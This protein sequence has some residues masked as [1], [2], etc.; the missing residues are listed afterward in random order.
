MRHTILKV[1]A[2]FDVFSYPLT[3]DEL[4]QYLGVHST[5]NEL[6]FEALQQLIETRIIRQHQAFLYLGS[7]PSVV[8]R[9]ISGNIRA[10]QR[11]RQARFY[12]RII[13]GFPFV[14]G[15]FLSGSIS[16][17]FM[18]DNDDIDYFIVTTPDRL[19]IARSMLTIFKKV[20]LLNSHKNFCI[21]YFVDQNHL[22]IQE[23]NRF[24]AT[25]LAFIVPMYDQGV[26]N[27]IINQNQWVRQFYPF[28]KE[29][30]AT[31]PSL[32]PSLFKRLL[33]YI[34]KGSVFSQLDQYLLTISKKYIRK[35]YAYMDQATFDE[36][37]SIQAYELRYL[38]NR[39]Q[40]RIM[41]VFRQKVQSLKLQQE[42]QSL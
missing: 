31:A 15:V 40:S 30:F 2:Y 4:K 14:R 1:M 16:K 38:P 41:R 28:F 11:L 22:Y 42:F 33:E 26:Y 5:E 18:T 12:S 21:N 39:Q 8:K 29:G 35:K 27:P 20:F 34:M 7:C 24:T 23:Q 6:F 9:R 32:R 36:A 37:F 25:E 19:W 13:S 17:G 3:T 10:K